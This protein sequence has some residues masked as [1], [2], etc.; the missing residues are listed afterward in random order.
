M[1]VLITGGTGFIGSRLALRCVEQGYSVRVLGQENTPA[2]SENRKLIEQKGAEVIL[3]SVTDRKSLLEL[4]KGADIVF[5]LA[6]AQHEMNIP[7]QRF[8]DVNVTGTKNMLEASLNAG[9]KRFVHGSTIGV[10]GSPEGMIDENSPCKPDN[11]YGITKLEGERLVLSFKEKLHVVVVRIPETY[12]P[13]DRR[14]MKLFKAINKNMFLMLGNG[15]NLHHPIYI[16]DL[17]DGL[18]LAAT[19]EGAIGEIFVLAGKEAITTDDMVRTIAGQIS[20]KVPKF[21]IPLHPLL[22]VATI[23]E[24]LL[25]PVGIQPPLHRRRMDFFKK[26][27]TFSPEKSA[28]ILGFVPKVSFKEGI[29]ETAKWYKEKG[30]SLKLKNNEKPKKSEMGM[31]K[32]SFDLTAKIEEFDTFWEGPEDVEKGYSTFGKFYRSNY[33][34][35]L[36]ADKQVDILVISCGPGYFVNMLNQEGYT[37]VIGIDSYAE[38][39]NFAEEK[40]LNCRVERA[41]DFL[42]NNHNPFDVIFG[43]QEINHLT[44]DEILLFLKLCRKNLK[45]G[46]ILIV[47]SLNGAN[48]ITGAEALAQNFDHYNTFTEYSLR[49]VL[50]Y[51]DFHEIRVFPLNLYVFYNNPLNYVGL[52]LDKL[53]ALFF[54][55]NFIL[56]GKSNKIFSKKIA[57]V[58]RK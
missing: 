35:Y 7:D 20:R 37:N 24:K 21:R 42:E 32:S 23:L 8:W 5:H 17:I 26:S 11:I 54:R 25:R 22:I 19:T 15:K 56:Y 14:L 2:E 45:D 40:N 55:F 16:D 13:G 34:K 48:P 1:R 43:E 49:Q 27:F 3:T 53:N 52:L 51:S 33:L 41:F 30:L 10:Y 38:K 9:V 6:A 57:A 31:M 44:K 29:L 18:L 58:C 12:G 46:G 39:V 28:N 4:V 50:E 47:H 36:P